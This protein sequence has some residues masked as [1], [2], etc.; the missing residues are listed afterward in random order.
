MSQCE[1]HGCIM[2]DTVPTVVV[3]FSPVSRI[4]TG[5]VTALSGSVWQWLSGSE[6]RL[7]FPFLRSL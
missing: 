2:V 3:S 7:L 5:A 4:T 1:Y 6:N